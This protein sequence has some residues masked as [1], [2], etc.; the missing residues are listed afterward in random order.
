[1]FLVDYLLACW[2]AFEGWIHKNVWWADQNE[3]YEKEQKRKHNDQTD[4]VGMIIS[5]KF[6]TGL[7]ISDLD[8]KTKNWSWRNI[9][10]F[11]IGKSKWKT[12]KYKPIAEI[13]LY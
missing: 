3:V 2:L 4:L 11:H 6:E 9:K 13:I 8:H 7:K 5:S 12:S 1:M 10:N